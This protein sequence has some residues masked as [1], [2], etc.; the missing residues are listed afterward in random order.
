MTLFFEE[1]RFV[2]ECPTYILYL[3]CIFPYSIIQFVP[4]SPEFPV[5]WRLGLEI[6][7]DLD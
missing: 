6:Q 1:S 7:L 5:G 3:F 4:L 2:L